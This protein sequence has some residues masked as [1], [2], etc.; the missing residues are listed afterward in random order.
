MGGWEKCMYRVMLV[1]DEEFILQGI[2][3]IIDWEKLDLKVVHMAHDGMEALQLWEMEEVDI[4]ITDISMPEM[5]GLQLMEELRKRAEH[6]R[7]IILSGYDEFEYAR[8]AI[9]L[10]VENYIL[11]PIDEEQLEQVLKQSVEKL[12]QINLKQKE[13]ITYGMELNYFVMEN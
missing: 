12:K 2:Y 11:K 8:K 9:R 7:F 10:D 13:K 6:V 5:N 3:Q 1:E 4:V